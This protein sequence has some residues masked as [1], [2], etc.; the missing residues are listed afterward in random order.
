[1]FFSLCQYKFQSNFDIS[2]YGKKYISC[3]TQTNCHEASAV[4]MRV[5]YLA[6]TNYFL[7]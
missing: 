6:T 4:I 3:D 1:M 2:N 5:L 7:R